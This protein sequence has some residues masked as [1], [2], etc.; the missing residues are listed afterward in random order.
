MACAF[1]ATA[2]TFAAVSLAAGMQH[3]T[4]V[5]AA[6]A[7][8]RAVFTATVGTGMLDITALEAALAA[9]QQSSDEAERIKAQEEFERLPLGHQHLIL[10]VATV[11]GRCDY[12]AL[13][14]I[15]RSWHGDEAATWLDELSLCGAL[16]P[17]IWDSKTCCLTPGFQ[18]VA[19]S[20]LL[21]P[22]SRH[23]GSRVW[24]QGGVVFGWQQVSASQASSC[25]M[26][27]TPA[28]LR[29]HANSLCGKAWS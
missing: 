5:R 26:V 23:Y 4:T 2:F 18:N 3:T 21:D 17:S 24:V 25:V 9:W 10:D 22:Q 28:R 19:H 14:R 6:L 8:A 15:W 7:V 11:G 27:L 13:K 12:D 1:N 20:I 16:E 29:L